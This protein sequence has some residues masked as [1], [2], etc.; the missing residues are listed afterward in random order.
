MNLSN[1]FE[2]VYDLLIFGGA[3][4]FYYLSKKNELVVA[5]ENAIARAEKEYKDATNAGGKKFEYAVNL[6]YTALPAQFRMFFTRELIADVVQ[7]TFN[8]I[9]EYA[10]LQLKETVENIDNA[11]EEKLGN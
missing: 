7:T 8:R 2:I 5:A 3:V 9:E 10:K 6:I 11:I 4:V 1:I